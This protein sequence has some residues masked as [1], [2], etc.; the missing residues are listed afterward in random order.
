MGLRPE[1]LDVVPEVDARGAVPACIAHL[2]SLGYETLVYLELEGDD[3][4]RLVA[5]LV[6]MPALAAGQQV[7]LVVDPAQ[8]RLSDREGRLV[9]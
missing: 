6:G 5:R 7:G 8:V 1:A 4:A 3:A 2:E 9:R